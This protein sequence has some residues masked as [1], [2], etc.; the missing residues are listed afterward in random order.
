LLDIVLEKLTVVPDTLSSIPGVG[1]AVPF[2]SPVK[3]GRSGRSR[4]LEW[5]LHFSCLG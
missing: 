3:M 4:S 2:R 1:T 5:T